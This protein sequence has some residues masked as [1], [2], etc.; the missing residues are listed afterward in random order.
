MNYIEK[1]LEKYAEL[2]TSV[3]RELESCKKRN[4][5]L[6]KVRN[7]MAWFLSPVDFFQISFC[8]TINRIRDVITRQRY[9]YRLLGLNSLT[10]SPY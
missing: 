9:D 8:E 3:E 6:E 2:K 4:A 7:L 10:Y 1:E 5:E